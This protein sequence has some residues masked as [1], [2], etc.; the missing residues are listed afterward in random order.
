MPE[1]E[2][3]RLSPSIAKVLLEKSPLH[4]WQAHRLL[5]GGKSKSSKAMD[6]G[7]LIEH[8]LGL[9][10]DDL[11]DRA[12]I[13]LVDAED[14]RT[15]AAKEERDAAILAGKLPILKGDYLEAQYVAT[16]LLKVMEKKHI[17][18]VGDKQ[19]RLEWNSGQPGNPNAPGVPCSGVADLI[20]QVNGEILITDLKTT[21]NA[22]PKVINRKIVD[23][24]YDVQGA[25]YIEALGVLHP[26][27]AG[28]ISFRL[29]FV[30]PFAPFAVTPVYFSGTMRELGE[31]KWRRAVDAWGM[32]M[33]S[34]KWH[35]YCQG[36]DSII[37]DALPWQLDQD[38]KADL[39]AQDIKLEGE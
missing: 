7:K 4:A 8:S 9:G 27:W 39:E 15:K 35:D 2:I 17:S 32:A 36:R 19:V 33:A 13:V 1:K 29:L 34:G 12:D 20:Q 16:E 24:G 6:L 31:R 26:E 18:L 30:E 11:E 21:D 38:I 22:S 5:G 3:V 23:F 10:A 14:W 28:R 25:A 37:I